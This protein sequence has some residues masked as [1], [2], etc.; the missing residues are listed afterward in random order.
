MRVDEVGFNLRGYVSELPAHPEAPRQRQGGGGQRIHV[1]GSLGRRQ[2]RR[3][4]PCEVDRMT[5][6]GHRV[7]PGSYVRRIQETDDENT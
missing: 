7:G 4:A 3:I 6:P 2:P 1:C 5:D